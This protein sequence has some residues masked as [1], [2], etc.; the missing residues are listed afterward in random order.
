VHIGFPVPRAYPALSCPTLRPVSSFLFDD[1]AHSE[2]GYEGAATRLENDSILRR[3]N[4]EVVF[5]LFF[6][7]ARALPRLVLHSRESPTTETTTPS[8]TFNP[9][10]LDRSSPRRHASCIGVNWT[11]VGS[12]WTS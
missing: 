12:Y 5:L 10:P 3:R 8:N 9:V 4:H 1:V 6:S 11:T 7:F 2:R